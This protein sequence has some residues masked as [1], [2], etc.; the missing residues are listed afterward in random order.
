M[1]YSRRHGRVFANICQR[2]V[3]R[4][5]GI[6]TWR[7]IV[8]G[9]LNRNNLKQNRTIVYHYLKFLFVLQSNHALRVEDNIRV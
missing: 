5:G 3:D 1:L 8:N 2:A 7:L 6:F 9:N 4:Y